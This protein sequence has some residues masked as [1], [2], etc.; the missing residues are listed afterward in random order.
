MYLKNGVTRTA[1]EQRDAERTQG[2]GLHCFQLPKLLSALIA[3]SAL[4]LIQL[5]TR[6]AALVVI[7]ARSPHLTGRVTGD[8][9]AGEPS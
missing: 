8:D 1:G 3:L 2:G 7:V 5:E 9:A 6:V 4:L